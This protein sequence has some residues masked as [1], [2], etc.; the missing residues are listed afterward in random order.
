MGRTAKP[1]TV[2]WVPDSPYDA[3]HHVDT[4]RAT[5]ATAPVAITDLGLGNKLFTKTLWRGATGRFTDDFPTGADVVVALLKHASSFDLLKDPTYVPTDRKD[6]VGVGTMPEVLNKLDIWIDQHERTWR[7]VEGLGQ[8]DV[9]DWWLWGVLDAAIQPLVSDVERADERQWRNLRDHA[10]MLLESPG[11]WA[12]L[13][14]DSRVKLWLLQHDYRTRLE[15]YVAARLFS[16]GNRPT[17]ARDGK[18]WALLP[19]YDDEVLGVPREL[20]EMSADE[21]RLRAMLREVRW[22]AVDRVELTVFAAIDFVHL[23]GLPAVT[24]ALVEEASGQRIELALQQYRDPRGNQRGRQFQDFSW[25]AFVA[26]VEAAELVAASLALGMEAVGRTWGLE[27]SM[28]VD[29]VFRSGPITDV[30]AQGS[31]G[32]VG[33]PHLA[34]RPVAGALVGFSPASTVAGVRVLPQVGPRLRSLDVDG[35]T[36]SGVLEP[37]DAPVIAVQVSSGRVHLRAEVVPAQNRSV[38]FRLEVRGPGAADKTW[39]VT[40]LTGTGDELRI[41][42]PA[43]APQWL[44]SG[45]VVGSRDATGSLELQEA[46]GV[47]VL[48]EVAL[49]GL[50]ITATGRWL[51]GTAPVDARIRLVGPT[52][53]LQGAVDATH[54]GSVLVR[55]RLVTDQWGIGDTPV[56]NGHYWFTVFSRGRVA[57]ALLGD[58]AV[59]RLHHF[60]VGTAYGARLVRGGRDCGV[61]LVRPLSADERGPYAQGR[62]EDWFRNAPIPLDENAVYFQSYLVPPRRT[63]S[64]RCTRN[65]AEPVPT[66]RCTGA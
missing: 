24:C 55:F 1:A 63:A 3:A 27:V 35:R 58:P 49:D 66:S 36:V 7:L 38:A 41:G 2:G 15:E 51:S 50:E 14:A 32:F 9:R 45:G 5:L 65:C 20:Y 48:D 12:R 18:V 61:E 10:R 47:L 28:S 60:M 44:G 43:L 34:P 54:E 16:N 53:S 62:L 52:V 33:R 21:T 25:G 31:A 19:F 40:A 57:R 29:G 17:V 26:T 42:W 13:S 56:P 46:E 39:R 23:E 6:G 30:D 37:I 8:L 59:D 22:I 11:V 64:G 4:L